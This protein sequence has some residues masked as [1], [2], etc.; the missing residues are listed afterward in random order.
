M[1]GP[2]PAGCRSL[3]H[4][5]GPQGQLFFPHSNQPF[6]PSAARH[7]PL[8]HP[9]AIAF[10]PPQD[11]VL[12]LYS[13]MS[14][15]IMEIFSEARQPARWRCHAQQLVLLGVARMIRCC[16]LRLR[17]AGGQHWR[18]H[19]CCHTAA[20]EHADLERGHRPF[21]SHN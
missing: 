5:T 10:F 13:T 1:R 17:G 7:L 11:F 9:C 15:T 3:V 14:R 20:V 18:P 6:S 12:F 16:V 8:S 21:L 2:A 4:S 19:F